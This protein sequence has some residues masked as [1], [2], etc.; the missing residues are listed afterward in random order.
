MPK[1]SR[2]QKTP[3]ATLKAIQVSQRKRAN[4]KKATVNAHGEHCWV[5]YQH[6][7]KRSQRLMKQNVSIRVL[8]ADQYK[9]ASVIEDSK[10]LNADDE[11]KIIW[12]N[13]KIIENEREIAEKK[14]K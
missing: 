7:D 6:A 8:V 11:K 10:Q 4:K 12:I 2:K 9:N 3:K 14:K 13:K 1:K 5:A